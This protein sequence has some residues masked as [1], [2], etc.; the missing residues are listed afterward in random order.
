MKKPPGFLKALSLLGIITSVIAIIVA[1]KVPG[2]IAIAPIALALIIGL[3]AVIITRKNSYKCYGGYI[4]STLVIIGLII[5]LV[6]QMKTPEIAIDNE[7]QKTLEETDKE[8]IE[9]E[10]LDKMLDEIDSDELE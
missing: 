5:L 6:Q 4:T 3:I 7:Q 2:N 8:I 1:L 9:S 10:E